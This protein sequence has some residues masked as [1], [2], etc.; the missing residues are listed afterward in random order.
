VR[1]C[2]DRKAA[3]HPE[4]SGRVEVKIKIGLAGDVTAAQVISSTLRDAEVGACMARAILALRLPPVPHGKVLEVIRAWQLEAEDGR[5]GA[6][7]RCSAASRQ[8]LAARRALWRERL[9]ASSGVEGAMAVWRQAGRSCELRTWLDRRSLL[10]ILRPHAGA[11]AQQFD[12]YHR[13][14]GQADV[15]GYLRREILR[16]VRTADDVRAIR[17]GLALDGG[18]S[19]ELLDEQIAKARSAEARVRVVRQFLA[20]APEG[21]ALR[22]RLLALLEEAHQIAEADRVAWS[23]R[24]DPAADVQARQAVGEYFARRKD[25]G[26]AARAFSEIVEFAP[27]DPWARRRLGDLYRAAGRF[28]DAYRE[29]GTLGWLVPGDG[30]VLL[31]ADAAAGAGRTDEA[32]RLQ[33]RVA[34]TVEAKE[35]A[36]GET[37]T[38]ARYWISVRLA[39]LRADARARKDDAQLERLAA[40]GRS[41]G[42]LTFAGETLVAV[43]W[44]HPDAR[45][46]LHVASPGDKL[47]QRAPVQGGAVGIEALR[48]ARQSPGEYRIAIRRAVSTA[49]RLR[50]FDGELW[51]LWDEAGVTERL[52]RLPIRFAPG[53]SELDFV[54]RGR[55]ALPGKEIAAAR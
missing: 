40:R 1:V 46:E 9:A 22:L 7:T 33:E 50:S 20:L 25:P 30:A 28:E 21:I 49:D 42:L 41:D 19:G 47:P 16:A 8:Y 37:S 23:L 17:G 3:G 12:L 5:L 14:D 4:L 43:T 48:L 10:D 44:S 45:L 53:I 15:Q 32:L 55:Q 18:V 39:A 24:G 36:G 6:A 11:T 26:E 27:F 52:T 29:Y 51:L 2:Y 38:W 13:F 35:G 34:E 54:V 31:L